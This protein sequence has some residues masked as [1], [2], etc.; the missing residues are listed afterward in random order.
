MI[1]GDPA[2]SLQAHGSFQNRDH[3]QVD[4]GLLGRQCDEALESQ[5]IG[6]LGLPGLNQ[7]KC[8]V[9]VEKARSAKSRCWRGEFLLEALR[10]KQF[11]GCILASYL[12]HERTR[13]GISSLR[14][15][16]ER[17]LSAVRRH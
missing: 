3:T 16:D 14:N 4:P 8:I 6:F 10:E 15:G 12:K 2:V 11:H 9:S 5:C 1:Q 13:N 17:G 7:Q